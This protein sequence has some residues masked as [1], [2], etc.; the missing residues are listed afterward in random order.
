MAQTQIEK[1]KAACRKSNDGGFGILYQNML[2]WQ[3][4]GDWEPL[5]YVLKNHRESPKLRRISSHIFADGVEVFFKGEE[6]KGSKWGVVI[7]KPA[8]ANAIFNE[9]KLALL[10][11]MVRKN[12]GIK[13]RVEATVDGE[14]KTVVA[15]THF[16]PSVA[17]A[18]PVQ[19]EDASVVRSAVKAAK[20]NNINREAF[21][22]MCE[23]LWNEVEVSA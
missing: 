15:H 10:E 4:H 1:T 7:R 14:K 6:V 17:P 2:H 16:F 18:E 9:N 12:L 22:K 3:N 21:L 20:K 11:L 19:R 23:A 8:G 5:A 13:G